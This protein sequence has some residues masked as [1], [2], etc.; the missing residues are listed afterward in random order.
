[1]TPR[2]QRMLVILSWCLAGVA[3]ALAAYGLFAFWAV[4]AESLGKRDMG[5]GLFFAVSGAYA[6]I[7]CLWLA[8][9]C[10]VLALLSWL[11]RTGSAL[12]CLTAAAASG[13]PILFLA[14]RG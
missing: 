4:N 1:V 11:T 3:A 6:L 9:A 2:T 7:A 8:P 10:A 12:A 5:F 13:L 14:L